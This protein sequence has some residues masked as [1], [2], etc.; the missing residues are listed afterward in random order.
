M[1]LISKRNETT[2]CNMYVVSTKNET[3]KAGNRRSVLL[4]K[5]VQN[6]QA[7]ASYPLLYTNAKRFAAPN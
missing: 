7:S 5:I 4:R 2:S 6:G 1:L 3:G